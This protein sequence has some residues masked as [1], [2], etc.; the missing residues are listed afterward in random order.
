[1]KSVNP[2]FEKFL[3]KK[4]GKKTL[5]EKLSKPV[6]QTSPPTEDSIDWGMLH[7]VYNIV[8]YYNL[9]ACYQRRQ[10]FQDSQSFI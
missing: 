6:L 2:L 8:T 1:M 7:R 5:N 3:Q 10:L 9:A 4:A